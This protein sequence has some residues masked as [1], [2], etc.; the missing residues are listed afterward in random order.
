MKRNMGFPEID[1]VLYLMK[2]WI[3]LK[4]WYKDIGQNTNFVKLVT[5]NKQEKGQN[6]I[7]RG[8]LLQLKSIANYIKYEIR[9][10]VGHKKVW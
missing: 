8:Q 2:K 3:F 9:Q 6:W 10:K 5:H 4:F 7:Y 1:F